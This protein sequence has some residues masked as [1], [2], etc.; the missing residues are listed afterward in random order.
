MFL[1]LFCNCHYSQWLFNQILI[2]VTEY[3][4]YLYLLNALQ[5]VFPR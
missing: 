2:N 1:P 5:Q 3:L 4:M